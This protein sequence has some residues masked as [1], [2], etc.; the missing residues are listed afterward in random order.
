MS[1]SAL[2]LAVRVASINL[3][4][5]EYL[6]L[7]A[8]PREIASISYLARDPLE[9]S[10]WKLARSHHSNHGTVE[11]VLP[12]RPNL[13]LA[14]GGG[15][16][17]RASA[18]LA[19]RMRIGTVDLRPASSIDDVAANLI[20]VADALGDRGRATPW[21]ARLRKLRQARPASSKDAILLTGSGRSL[22]QGSAGIEWL[23][24]AGLQQRALP[25]A[26]ATLETLLTRP[27]AVLI[28]SNY[29][30]AQ[31][32]RGT[33]WLNHPVVRNIKAR[34]VTTDGRAWTCMGPLMIQEI[35]RLREAAR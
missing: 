10:L 19:A 27:P 17:G 23:R 14:M 30:R 18:L 21:L 22:P 13:L 16:G 7:L 32:S 8:R 2:L 3:C 6:L 25:G 33:G 5:D 29:R 1:A 34:R 11:Q 26:Q 31:V 15:R 35:E 12:V 24:L 20:V 4:T 28:E 9:S